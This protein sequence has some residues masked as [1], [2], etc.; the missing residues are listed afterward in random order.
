MS[1]WLKEHDWKSCR[2][3]KGLLGSNP[4]LSEIFGHMHGWDSKGA[5]T[6][7]RSGW[8]DA[9]EDQPSLGAAG[10]RPARSAA[11]GR[12]RIPASPFY[13]DW[14]AYV[15]NSNVIMSQLAAKIFE[16]LSGVSNPCPGGNHVSPWDLP[17]ILTREETEGFLP[18]A[19]LFPPRKG[20]RDWTV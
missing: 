1:E 15:A 2:S 18:R 8:S 7:Q 10:G 5:A 3:H 19:T 9:E 20:S 17:S 14:T 11:T 4:S 13:T 16:P 6:R 12:R